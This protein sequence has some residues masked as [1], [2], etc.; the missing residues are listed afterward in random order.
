MAKSSCTTS[1]AHRILLDS[2][3]ASSVLNVLGVVNPEMHTYVRRVLSEP[4]A[5]AS[6]T[7]LLD[8]GSAVELVGYVADQ[9]ALLALHTDGRL[10]VKQAVVER[11]GELD[12][13]AEVAA[14]GLMVL[15]PTGTALTAGS[16]V[17][18][19]GALERLDVQ[20]LRAWAIANPV[21]AQKH[22]NAIIAGSDHRVDT[23]DLYLVAMELNM[24]LEFRSAEAALVALECFTG[25][26]G[27]NGVHLLERVNA[28]GCSLRSFQGGPLDDAA[29]AA[30]ANAPIAV[31]LACGVVNDNELDLAMGALVGV[32]DS[33]RRSLVSPLGELMEQLR[34]REH[35]AVAVPYLRQLDDMDDALM[36]AA[37]WLQDDV[38]EPLGRIEALALIAVELPEILSYDENVIVSDEELRSV[39]R[40][41]V[42][43][44]NDEQ[45][46]SLVFE[47]CS[48]RENE[49]LVELLEC[50]LDEL[51][52]TAK[53]VLDHMEF[54]VTWAARQV[55][56][57][58]GAKFGDNQAA[59][60]VFLA[61]VGTFDGL[62]D[63]L[64][65]GAI[66]GTA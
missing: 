13:T 26:V 42:E 8:A 40:R 55:M 56:S 22:W 53:Y 23:R 58:V 28:V 64:V 34:T 29:R 11:V 18:A 33:Q 46:M 51:P 25:P 45:I 63:D 54:L 10:A 30:L 60:A 49:Q 20:V 38:L 32:V 43:F 27:L 48:C 19:L 41:L 4:V 14:A 39:V 5:A 44:R 52:M 17:S 59:W 31:R 15:T 61:Q 50:C 37:I 24:Q 1:Y 36:L 47:I 66:A 57:R 3:P 21:L 2:A 16:L 62:L 65:T 6:I 9:Q 35:I 7:R 12:L